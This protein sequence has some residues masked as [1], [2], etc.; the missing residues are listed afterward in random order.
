MTEKILI[1]GM[2]FLGNSIFTV[3][4]NKGMNVVGTHHSREPSLDVK[5]IDI[6]E[7]IIIH[8]S[9]DFI[10][11]CA[12]LTNIDQI[13]LEPSL[14]YSVNAEGA[15]NVASIALKKK[16]KLIHIS[17]DSVFDGR[18]KLYSEIDMPNPINEYA[19]SK[20]L[21]ED[22]VKE[23]S[24]TFVIVRTNFYGH[25]KEGKFLFNWILDSLRNRQ[26]IT[27]FNDII[28]NPLE[29]MNLANILIE[30]I[31]TDYRGIIHLSSDQV[32]SKYQFA[33]KIAGVLGFDINLIKKGTIEDSHFVAKRPLNTSLSNFKAK[34]L[35]KTKIV[36][37]DDWLKLQ[38]V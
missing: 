11:N 26:M 27:A 30:L 22:Y 21:G 13:E 8:H 17:T 36:S 19:K 37:L 15:K 3:A 7:K 10:I 18:G 9:P 1:I 35:L 29:I 32:L 28:F 20:K 6:V 4:N 34:K 5:N 31:H 12:A 23:I 25:N 33:M 16:I 24:D 38:I 14:A 2:G